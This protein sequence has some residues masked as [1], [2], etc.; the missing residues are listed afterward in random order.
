MMDLSVKYMGLTLKSPIIVGSSGLT[1]N[2]DKIKELEKNGAGAVVLKSLFEEQLTHEGNAADDKNTYDYPEALDYI[3][4]FTRDSSID[5]YLNLI[6]AC[7]KEVSI[8][9]IA[10]VNCVSDG[11][12]VNFAQKMEKA[13]A[14]ALEINISLLPSDVNKSSADNEK[15]YFENNLT[16]II[17]SIPDNFKKNYKKLI[18]KISFSQKS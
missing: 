13:G 3:K 11:E 9:I 17:Q 12:W 15:M 1:N 14:D 4:S 2:L 7:K 8:P 10:S 18:A 6:E 5:E 16:L